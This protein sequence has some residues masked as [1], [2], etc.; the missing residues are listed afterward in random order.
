MTATGIRLVVPAIGS[1]AGAGTVSAS[2]VLN[3]AMRATIQN[4]GGILSV[5]GPIGN[6]GSV[7]F[8]IAGTSSDPVFQPDMN[9]LANEKVGT[10]QDT[11]NQAVKKASDIFGGLMDRLTPK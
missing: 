6:T 3:F 11:G 1:I 4:A 5:L 8:F 7:P 2:H 9:G 10:M